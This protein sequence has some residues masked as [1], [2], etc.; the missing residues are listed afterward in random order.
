MKHSQ[1]IPGVNLID[2]DRKLILVFCVGVYYS[3]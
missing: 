3:I 1:G 2:E